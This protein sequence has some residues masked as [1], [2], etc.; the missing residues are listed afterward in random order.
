ME[1]LKGRV[2]GAQHTHTH[3]HTFRHEYRQRNIYT[4][5]RTCQE[6]VC[7]S[8]CQMS[9]ALAEVG[10]L[11]EAELQSCI[12]TE[13]NPVRV[14]FSGGPQLWVNDCLNLGVSPRKLLD[15]I[16]AKVGVYTHTHTQTHTH[17]HTAISAHTIVALLH[18]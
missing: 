14:G 6:C 5:K 12:D 11:S 10:L 18:S 8:V 17:T 7:V 1:H 13:F 15:L 2:D 9:Q 16:K 3:T 4:D